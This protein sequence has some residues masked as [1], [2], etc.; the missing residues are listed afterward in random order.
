M[1]AS[2]TI[3]NFAAKIGKPFSKVDLL[4]AW[5]SGVKISEAS[6]MPIIYRLVKN[7]R[8]E[9]VDNGLY[10]VPKDKKPRFQ[11]VPSQE[12]KDI[13]RQLDDKLPF[14]NKCVWRASVFTPFMRHV[15]NNNVLFVDIDRVA[16]EAAFDLLQNSDAEWSLFVSPTTK[17][18]MRMVPSKRA[19][20]IRPLVLEAP[21]ECV[22]GI[23]VPT[24]EKL[25]VD[26]L[27][28]RELGYLQ[29]A[30]LYTVYENITEQYSVNTKRLYRY[31]SRRNRKEDLQNILNSIGYDTSR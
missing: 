29:G 27:K 23:M 26:A 24:I 3:E 17:E 31:S 16:M 4:A 9:R 7:G 20:I 15:P 30:E 1:T 14:A 11:Y 12:E 21:T 18:L 5:P 8:L 28:D 6:V 2:Q 13:Y 22:D 19:I 10:S 25:M